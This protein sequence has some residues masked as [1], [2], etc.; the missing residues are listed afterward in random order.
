MWT[1]Q[2]IVQC[3]LSLFGENYLYVRCILINLPVK[4]KLLLLAKSIGFHTE[5]GF[6]TSFVA[7][8]CNL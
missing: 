8:L 6:D 1:G 7:V 5:Q 2:Q 4:D 3:V